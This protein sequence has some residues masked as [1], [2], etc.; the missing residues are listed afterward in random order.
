ML[1]CPKCRRKRHVITKKEKQ[2]GKFYW[3][4]HCTVCGSPIKLEDE[5]KTD[6]KDK[7]E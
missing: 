5:I 7:D 1:S 6:T 2:K 4:S 3:V